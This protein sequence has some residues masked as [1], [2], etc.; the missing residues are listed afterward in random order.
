M[1]VARTLLIS[2]GLLGCQIQPLNIDR[3]AIENQ[4]K[5]TRLNGRHYPMVLLNTS[6]PVQQSPVHIYIEGDGLPWQSRTQVSSDP[7]PR[8]PV[9]LNL[10]KYDDAHSVYLGRPCYF[11][12]HTDPRCSSKLWTSDRYSEEIV[13]EMDHAISDY[14]EQNQVRSAILIGYSGGGTLALLL[15]NRNPRIQG[16]MMIASNFDT[17]AWVKLHEFTPLTGSLNPAREIKKRSFN[18]IYW[19]GENDSN[20]P[21]IPFAVTAKARSSAKVRTF[22]G[23]DHACCWGTVAQSGELAEALRSLITERAE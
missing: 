13:E 21:P 19:F 12:F 14:L 20:V 23:V 15:A 11:G 7:T 4:W 6:S 22:H 9:A 3:T 1:G 8:N 17:A 18:E 2:T 16:A 5:I 10:M